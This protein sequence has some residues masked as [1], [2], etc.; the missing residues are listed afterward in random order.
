MEEGRAYTLRRR[1]RVILDKSFSVFNK[2]ELNDKGL[3]S[4][5]GIVE[6]QRIEM[7]PDDV[8]LTIQSINIV[9]A[10]KIEFY[11]DRRI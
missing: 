1:V 3:M 7:Q 10:E 5:I 9:K 6:G 11:G 8:E 2:L 4:L